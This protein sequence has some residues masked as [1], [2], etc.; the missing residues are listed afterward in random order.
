MTGGN[1]S[2]SGGSFCCE[3]REFVGVYD[4]TDYRKSR[5]SSLDSGDEKKLIVKAL[6]GDV[7]AQT[8][9]VQQA[10]SGGSL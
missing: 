4:D 10:S 1:L 8:V 6:A 5:K 9:I 3:N 7:A 2:A